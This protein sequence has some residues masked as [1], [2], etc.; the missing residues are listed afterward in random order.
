MVPVKLLGQHVKAAV[1]L[2]AKEHW[3]GE[4]LVIHK[5]WY[6][7]PQGSPTG[8]K[9]LVVNEGEQPLL[10]DAGLP[11]VGELVKQDTLTV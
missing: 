5:G 6:S 3:F 2:V 1:H 4:H 11:V 10:L 7:H 9:V 8:F